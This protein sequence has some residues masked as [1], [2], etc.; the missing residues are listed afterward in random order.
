M[1]IK[2]KIFSFGKGLETIKDIVS[3]KKNQI[4]FQYEKYNN[5]CLKLSR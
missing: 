2:D 3:L 4:E 1:M 5:Q